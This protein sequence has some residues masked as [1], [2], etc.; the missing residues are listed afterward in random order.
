M[1]VI[2]SLRIGC[3]VYDRG[4]PDLVWGTG[5]FRH[6]ALVALVRSDC[7][8]F[9]VGISW[10][11]LGDEA[12]YP[13]SA[14]TALAEVVVGQDVTVPFASSSLVTSRA[15][16][17]GYG[18][19]AAVVEAALFDLAGRRLG[20]PT[21][22]LLGA[23]RRELPSYVISAEEF[24]FTEV[25]QFVD[26]A[27]RYVEAGFRACKFHLW[28][29][30]DR[31]LAAC[32]AIRLALGPD[33]GLML[34]PVGRYGRDDAL[35][36]GRAIGELGFIRYEDPL[37]PLD[38]AGYRWL[39]PRIDVPIVVNESLRW[40]PSECGEAARAG[41]AQGFRLDVG[42]SGFTLGLSF[43]SA[44]EANG[45]ELDV[46]AFAPRGGLEACIAMSLAATTSRW[47]EHHEAV[48]LDEV[49]GVA[50]GFEIAGG[51]ART[52]DRPG[53]GCE[54]DLPELERHCVWA[55]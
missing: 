2:E 25:A 38:P 35:A 28:G 55:A 6:A 30:R 39:A 54:I 8:A 44:A 34:D 53:L 16:G 10:A 4:R 32:E 13:G 5:R 21:H 17:L 12:G 40:S 41:A 47:F 14:Q 51:L 31:D 46:A 15:H 24:S 9:G 33:I 42:R 50:P 49:P 7:G 45:A 27:H 11:H 37:S 26:L 22:H 19:A 29:E 36:V 43:A 1:P 52:K 20:V 18:R 23:K 3:A 48:G